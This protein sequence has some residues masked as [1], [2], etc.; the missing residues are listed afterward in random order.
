PPRSCSL[1][2][3][4]PPPASPCPPR[5]PA[6]ALTTPRPVITFPVRAVESRPRCA[7]PRWKVAARGKG[8]AA[9][10]ARRR[11][12]VSEVVE[13]AGPGAA[14]GPV[15]ASPRVR[16]GGRASDAVVH[17]VLERVGRGAEAGDLLHLQ[18]DVAV[19]EVIAHH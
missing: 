1:R 5:V 19:D 17:L 9:R 8:R 4:H 7:L 13:T 15:S 3:I 18:V 11:T 12:R 14:P 16:G 6:G 10:P 2:C